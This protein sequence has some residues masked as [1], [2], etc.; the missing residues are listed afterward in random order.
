MN[1]IRWRL[2]EMAFA[3]GILG[4][5]I[6]LYSAGFGH[7]LIF[8]DAWM[9]RNPEVLREPI[10]IRPEF[11]SLWLASYQAVY[12]L[13]GS[14][15]LWQRVFNVLL[16][17]VNTVLIWALSVRLLAHALKQELEEAAPDV[18]SG[19]V[20]ECRAT[21]RIVI[22]FAVAAWAFNPVAVYAVQYLTQRSTLMATG[23]VL[24]ELLAFIAALQSRSAIGRLLWLMI[25]AGAYILAVLSKEHAAPAVALLFPLYVYWQRPSRKQLWI[26]GLVMAGLAMIAALVT[27]SQKGLRVGVAYEDMVRPFLQQLEGLRPGAVEQVYSLSLVNQAWL[28]FRYGILWVLPW[29]GWL[30]VDLRPPFPL[31]WYAMPQV[32]G[33]LAFVVL[34]LVGGLALLLRRG[35]VA[36]AGLM[37]LVPI[38]LFSTEMAYVRLQ[39]P[40]VLYRS[41]LWS[42]ALPVLWVLVVITLIRGRQFIVA[43]GVGV[44]LIF[45]FLALDRIH[46]LRDDQTAWRDALSKI[47]G[48]GPPNALGRWRAPHNLA[49]WDLAERRFE[50]AVRH[51]KMADALGAP[52]GLAKQKLG[53][54]LVSLRR[55]Q[56]ALPVLL[57]AQEEGYDGAELWVSIGSAYD[58]LGRVDEAFVAYDRALNGGLHSRFR[59]GTLL[60]VGYLANRTGKHERAEAYF[61]ELLQL[62]P[63]MPAAIAGLAL[64]KAGQGDGKSALLILSEAIDRHPAAELYHAR[65]VVYLQ[66][67]NRLL[68]ERDIKRAVDLEPNNPLYRQVLRNMQTAGLAGPEKSP[69]P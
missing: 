41:Y 47:D 1:L 55:P 24:L 15:L 31:T 54:A 6:I 20:Q 13:M 66:D 2:P 22:P 57:A 32:L 51:A 21:V 60:A 29:V 36:L 5:L 8:D 12:Q 28:F 27:M 52:N 49:R 35:R 58:Q 14:E 46:S 26:A 42:I 45:A 69:K 33:A 19:R 64:A 40:F 65:A 7:Q 9:A 56:E 39:E 59:P 16:H 43:I 50:D 61:S 4:G 67:G 23:F 44:T 17:A 10:S 34:A 3:A 63:T 62:Q 18:Q 48:D 30:S 25:T 68:A 38:V 37:V 53:S 11:R